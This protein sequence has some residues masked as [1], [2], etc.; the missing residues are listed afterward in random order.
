M[1]RFP[2]AAPENNFEEK[3]E[4]S[5][6]SLEKEI[7]AHFGEEELAIKVWDKK[8]GEELLGV[9]KAIPLSNGEKIDLSFLVQHGVDDL[10]RSGGKPIWDVVTG[11][12]KVGET[13]TSLTDILPAGVRVLFNPEST[14]AFGVDQ[15]VRMPH[16]QTE[17]DFFAL[18]HEM[19]HAIDEKNHP[20]TYPISV[21]F[22]V[23]R[24]FI[25][26]ASPEEFSIEAVQALIAETIR[27]ERSA[28]ANAFW[29]ARKV[30][31]HAD[32]DLLTLA[33][34]SLST[35]DDASFEISFRGS[36]KDQ[37]ATSAR[38][39]EAARPEKQRELSAIADVARESR[40]LLA[41]VREYL[42]PTLPVPERV[43]ATRLKE[44][45]SYTVD[46]LEVTAD[47]P[48]L[49]VRK[50]QREED[51][52]HAYRTSYVAVRASHEVR[53]R[54]DE[55]MNVHAEEGAIES[56]RRALMKGRVSADTEVVSED[57]LEQTKNKSSSLLQEIKDSDDFVIAAMRAQHPEYSEPHRFNTETGQ[58]LSLEER[59][60][61]MK[62]TA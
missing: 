30:G 6:N 55:V 39:A 22:N 45:I 27:K 61:Q 32:R 47:A 17:Y 15:I 23:V 12:I 1:E 13:E 48:S 29:T 7:N 54:E 38:R 9:D 5:S 11:S 60:A 46:F 19:G 21:N 31:L 2:S 25:E 28:W 16:M 57:I 14:P 43:S 44:G 34:A 37:F 36:E 53:V 59:I 24:R 4:I 58:P 51:G 40:A 18:L 3:E 10:A 50:I 26:R 20:T 33:E 56:D 35:Y 42:D 49:A 41:H 62:G 52:G 8:E